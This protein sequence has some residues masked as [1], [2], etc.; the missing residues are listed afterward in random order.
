MEGGCEVSPILKPKLKVDALANVYGRDGAVVDH[1]ADLL[2]GCDWIGVPFGGGMGALA[3]L[4][5]KQGVANDLHRHIINLAMV[6]GVTHRREQMVELLEAMPCHEEAYEQAKAH[7]RGST[8]AAGEYQVLD[9]AMYFMTSWM[10]RGGMSGTSRE[11]EPGGF[12]FRMKATGGSSS[13]R[14]RSAVESLPAWGDVLRRWTFLCRDAL[15]FIGDCRDHDD[16]GLYIDS[17]FPGAG[18]KYLHNMDCGTVGEASAMTRLRD[19]LLRFK[20]CRVVIRYYDHPLIRE[21]YPPGHWR[22]E[23]AT[24]RAQS[25]EQRNEMLICNFDLKAGHC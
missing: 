12:S 7:C 13:S 19:A 11:F 15:E 10:G 5:C 24:S 23:E 25:N 8:L 20:K 21:L 4:R 1:V 3:R 9:A 22:I 18:E 6:V 2:D 14:W 16:N 17:P